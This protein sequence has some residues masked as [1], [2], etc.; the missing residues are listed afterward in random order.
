M[1][2]QVYFVVTSKTFQYFRRTLLRFWTLRIFFSF[3]Y[4]ALSPSA[5]TSALKTNNHRQQT[6]EIPIKVKFP[7]TTRLTVPSFI[8]FRQIWDLLSLKHFIATQ[9]QGLQ[10]LFLTQLILILS[11]SWKIILFS[12]NLFYFT[13]VKS[14]SVILTFCFFTSV[15]L[16]K[17]VRYI[18]F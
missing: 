17:V 15:S 5:G 13:K 2:W 10:R 9:A 18:N 7:K 14:L 8:E 6:N 11:S 4:M 12:Y 3:F 16:H 1:Q